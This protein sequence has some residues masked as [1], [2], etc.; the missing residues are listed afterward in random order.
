MKT[1][2][3]IAALAFSTSAIAFSDTDEFNKKISKADF[4]NNDRLIA[5]SSLAV[6]QSILKE[7]QKTRCL[8]ER[9]EATLTPSPE[10]EKVLGLVQ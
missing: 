5:L 7:V 1:I 3:L 2:I 9:I 4:I 10:C 8:T 6:Q